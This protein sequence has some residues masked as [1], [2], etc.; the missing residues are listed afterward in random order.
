MN[1]PVPLRRRLTAVLVATALAGGFAAAE[2]T[3]ATSPIAQHLRLVSLRS[4]IGFD[5]SQA[6]LDAAAQLEVQALGAALASLPHAQITVSGYA[7][8]TGPGELNLQLSEER[9]QSVRQALED[10]GVDP[11]RITLEANG[12]WFSQRV[13][14][15][16]NAQARQRRVDIRVEQQ[17]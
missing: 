9:A 8:A 15:E 12:E 2:E 14:A 10:A 4:S 17:L 6:Q 13:P 1:S 7:D 5:L 11:A 16:A 3:H